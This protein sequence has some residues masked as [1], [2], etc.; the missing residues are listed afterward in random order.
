MSQ[1]PQYTVPP[2]FINFGVGQPAESMLPLEDIRAATAHRF[3]FED[4]LLLQYGDIPGYMAFR[5]TLAKF[6]NGYE[7]Y[8]GPID[9]KSLFITNGNTGA[10]LLMCTFFTQAGYVRL[11]LNSAW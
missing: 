4:R 11:L 10:L 2:D 6:L 3:S 9:P 5:E 8:K 1:Y 7:E